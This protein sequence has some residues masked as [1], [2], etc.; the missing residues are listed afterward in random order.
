M[1]DE[2][3]EIKKLV[4]FSEKDVAGANIV[5]ILI[6]KFNFIK[7]GSLFDDFPIYSKGDVS[8]VR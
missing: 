8:I 4:V 2:L 5:K 6:E 3:R 1:S 7:T